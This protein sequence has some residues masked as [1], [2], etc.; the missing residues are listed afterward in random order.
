[1]RVKRKAQRLV[2]FAGSFTRYQG[3]V[4]K[5]CMEQEGDSFAN[6][7]GTAGVNALVPDFSGARAFFIL[8][9]E[10]KELVFMSDGWWRWRG[11]NRKLRIRKQNNLTFRRNL[12]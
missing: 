6:L 8:L 7:G 10:V 3:S 9:F 11:M 5:L 4:H 1:M 12:S 2:A